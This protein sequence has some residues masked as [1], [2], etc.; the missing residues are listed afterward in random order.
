MTAA[1]PVVAAPDVKPA[2]SKLR[3]PNAYVVTDVRDELMWMA[4]DAQLAAHA[5]GERRPLAERKFA[6]ARP[7]ETVKNL[8]ATSVPGLLAARWIV[9]PGQPWQIKNP[10]PPPP[11]V[12]TD[13][14]AS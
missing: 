1:P 10:A 6:R 13:E 7:G 12:V 2:P 14:E 4:D 8:P 5:K 11:V 3:D 9:K